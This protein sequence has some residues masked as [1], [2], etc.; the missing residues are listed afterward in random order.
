[1]LGT[2]LVTLQ[3]TPKEKIKEGA[4]KA[5]GSDKLEA[6]GKADQVQADLKSRQRNVNTPQH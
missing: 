4:G 3:K 1:V 2:R 6:E 5:T